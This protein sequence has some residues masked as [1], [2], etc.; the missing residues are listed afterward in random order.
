[1]QLNS[2]P[3]SSFLQAS[4][5]LWTPPPPPSVSSTLPLTRTITAQGYHYCRCNHSA[6][7]LFCFCTGS[8]IDG[9]RGRPSGDLNPSLWLWAQFLLLCPSFSFK[10]PDSSPSVAIRSGSLGMEG[11]SEAHAPA[12]RKIG[13]L[14]NHKEGSRPLCTFQPSGFHSR[15]MFLCWKM[16]SVLFLGAHGSEEDRTIFLRGSA[17]QACFEPKVLDIHLNTPHPH[18]LIHPHTSPQSPNVLSKTKGSF[19]MRTLTTKILIWSRCGLETVCI[20][21]LPQLLC[22]LDSC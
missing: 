2:F 22:F 17:A 20:A 16:R 19:Q 8:V 21:C 11:H 1:M 13:H 12:K 3:Q 10:G 6:V 18:P 15:K 4:S 5:F 9:A 14:K 7:L